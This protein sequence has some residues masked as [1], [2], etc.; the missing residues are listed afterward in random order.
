MSRTRLIK[1]LEFEHALILEA[2]EHDAKNFYVAV[3]RPTKSLTIGS[4]NPS[5]GHLVRAGYVQNVD[6][7]AVR[8]SVARVY[9]SEPARGLFAPECLVTCE[10]LANM[11][12][13]GRFTRPPG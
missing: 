6:D 1:G 5:D 10:T 7:R 11:S 4:R 13:T 12:R 3:P 9:R 8:G 2:S